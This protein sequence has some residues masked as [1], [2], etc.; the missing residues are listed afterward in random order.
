MT[1][2]MEENEMNELNQIRERF[3]ADAREHFFTDSTHTGK[4]HPAARQ[5]HNPCRCTEHQQPCGNAG[6]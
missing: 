6:A 2:T 1:T 3:L 5:N 4:A